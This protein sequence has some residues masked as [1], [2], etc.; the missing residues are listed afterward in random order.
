M[1]G[2]GEEVREKVESGGGEKKGK[3]KQRRQGMEREG[4][5][6]RRKGGGKEKNT[7]VGGGDKA[8]IGN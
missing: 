8:G 2:G 1:R 6:G 7:R 5:E 3:G 4:E